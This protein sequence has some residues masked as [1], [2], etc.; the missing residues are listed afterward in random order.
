LNY[1]IAWH[2]DYKNPTTIKAKACRLNVASLQPHNLL[3]NMSRNERY[4]L[5]KMGIMLQKMIFGYMFP[6]FLGG[7]QL[8]SG[9]AVVLKSFVMVA[10]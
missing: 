6:Y 7:A 5:F 4:L 1:T 3:F 9:C 2:Q 10:M 8:C